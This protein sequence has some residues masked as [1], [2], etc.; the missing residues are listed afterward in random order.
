MTG[1]GGRRN[2][3]TERLAEI[4]LRLSQGREAYGRATWHADVGFLFAELSRLTERNEQL[5]KA[6]GVIP[7]E[8]L[9]RLA[10]WLDALDVLDGHTEGDEVQRDLR[11]MAELSRAVLAGVGSGGQQGKDTH[12]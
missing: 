9:D 7:P 2:E 3:T 6:L 11:H 4:T 12:E 5:E 10:R 8:R 1:S